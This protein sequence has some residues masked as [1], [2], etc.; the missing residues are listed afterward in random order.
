MCFIY[1]FKVILN[2]PNGWTFHFSMFFK[3]TDT[4]NSNIQLLRSRPDWNVLKQGQSLPL[5]GTI[6]VNFSVCWKCV[7]VKISYLLVLFTPIRRT[8][9]FHRVTSH[10][11][12]RVIAR[13]KVAV[14][15]YAL[16]LEMCKRGKV[17]HG[18]T[19]I[20]TGRNYFCSVL[21]SFSSPE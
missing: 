16:D 11:A 18:F 1:Y 21:F 12:R 3:L 14:A 10:S 2:F 6:A 4:R 7:T 13:F 17:W 9:I 8:W 15:K 5:I 19:V 20:K